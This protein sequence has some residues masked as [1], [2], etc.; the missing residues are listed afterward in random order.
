MT[1]GPDDRYGNTRISTVLRDFNRLRD[2]IRAHDPD[3]TEEAWLRCELWLGL[4][5]AVA[6]KEPPK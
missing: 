1:G 6:G 2:A 3:A 4:V 5:Y